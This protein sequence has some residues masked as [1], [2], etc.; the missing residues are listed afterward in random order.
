MR[1]T[2]AACFRWAYLVVLCCVFAASP[3]VVR[4]QQ[5]TPVPSLPAP[6][7][8]PQELLERLGKVEQRLDWVTSQ[9]EALL[10]ENKALTDKSA[11]P[12][13]DVSNL[14]P[15]TSGA[16]WRPDTSGESASPADGS[17]NRPGGSAGGGRR[18]SGNDITATGVAQEVGNLHLGK[19][20]LTAYYDF[21]NSGFHVATRDGE[22][23]FAI[24]GM[25]QLDGMVYQ[26]PTPGDATSGFYNPRSRIYFEGHATE[27]IRWEF[28]F[29]N[30]YDTVA[31]L[32]AYVNFNYDARF[33]VQIGRYKNPFSY[34]FYRIH[35]WD[36]MAPERSLFANNYEANRR[37]GLMAHGDLLDQRVEYAVGTFDSQRNSLRPFNNRQ[38]VEA[39]VNFKPFYDGEEGLL[40]RDLQFGGSVDAGNENQSPVPAALRTN[41]SPGGAAVNSTAASN[42]ASLPFLAFNPGV[43]E[44]G[45]RALWETHL[46]YYYGGLSLVAA[47][48]GGHESYATGTNGPK[49]RVPIHGWFVQGAYIL[50]GETIRDR[51]LIQP[52]RPFDLREG[53]FGLGAWEVTAR[54]SDLNLDERVFTAGLADPKL[55]TNHAQLVDVGANWY[56]NQF[57]KVYFDWEH[58]IFGDPVFSSSGRFRKSNDLFWVRTQVYF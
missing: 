27:P 3:A 33:Q 52:L 2:H 34:E 50:T 4:G 30:F 6:A 56:L 7:G 44:R 36:L 14:S 11:A 51:T 46:A 23:S 31:L 9:N 49:T 25:T 32:D 58:A 5:G 15:T 53:R 21:D 19:V 42:A 39:F 22:F 41:Q 57:V 20:P 28:S 8:S 48:Q 24:S 38:D 10:L 29:Q 55:W 26:R 37:F 40:L 16:A 13:P 45:G 18:A 54:Y 1:T 43:L 17:R 35:V 47:L 12:F